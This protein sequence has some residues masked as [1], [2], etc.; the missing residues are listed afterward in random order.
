MRLIR[1]ARDVGRIRTS[2]VAVDGV[3][4]GGLYGAPVLAVP[5]FRHPAPRIRI[6]GWAVLGGQGRR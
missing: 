5:L 3:P 4:R 1:R 6:R 2:A